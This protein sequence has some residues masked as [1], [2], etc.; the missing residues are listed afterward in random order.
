[1]LTE[2]GTRDPNCKCPAGGSPRPNSILPGV[3]WCTC[4]PQKTLDLALT[5]ETPEQEVNT[6]VLDG[7]PKLGEAKDLANVIR[8][9]FTELKKTP[10]KDEAMDMATNFGETSG[11]EKVHKPGEAKGLAA[12][13]KKENPKW[14]ETESPT[15]INREEAYKLG[16]G[17]KPEETPK[18]KKAMEAVAAEAV[19]ALEAV[20]INATKKA[21]EAIATEA[22]ETLE[23]VDTAETAVKN[24][25]RSNNTKKA[26]RALAMKAREAVEALDVMTP[27]RP[28]SSTPP[29]STTTRRLWRLGPWRPTR[30]WRTEM[31]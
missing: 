1:M 29:L 26:L 23:G 4:G 28:L 15:A 19:E 13:I 16:E 21:V 18:R 12:T 14:E 31:S 6:K 5:T 3:T 7:T 11:P 17:P 8:E 22:V 10:G 20:V 27:W 24:A 9:Q 2:V 30:L 25:T